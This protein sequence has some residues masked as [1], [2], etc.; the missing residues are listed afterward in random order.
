M[1]NS[2]TCLSNQ[3]WRWYWY[4]TVAIRE[5]SC[6]RS[7]Q[8]GNVSFRESQ[9]ARSSAMQGK[10]T[11]Y[12]WCSRWDGKTTTCYLPNEHRQQSRGGTTTFDGLTL[13]MGKLWSDV[14]HFIVYWCWSRLKG[15]KTSN[16]GVPRQSIERFSWLADPI[17]KVLRAVQ[18][19]TYSTYRCTHY[20]KA[21]QTINNK[22][23]QCFAFRHSL[24]F[25]A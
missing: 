21:K 9:S 8:E 14:H 22:Q 10:W 2:C 25:F 11:C 17:F 24:C 18:V 15:V 5:E 1:L 19:P 23:A 7:R 16:H 12:R 13:K 4:C 6:C 3:C 20:N